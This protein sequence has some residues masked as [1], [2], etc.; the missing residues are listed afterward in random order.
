MYWRLNHMCVCI[1]QRMGNILTA[2]IKMTFSC[3]TTSFRSAK[4]TV[5]MKVNKLIPVSKINVGDAYFANNFWGYKWAIGNDE[6]HTCCFGANF[7][8]TNWGLLL[9]III[10]FSSACGQLCRSLSQQHLLRLED[11]SRQIPSA[12]QLLTSF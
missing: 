6:W 3:Y 10:L 4:T 5:D 8:L 1:F 11:N 12:K 2:P 7:L 9:Y